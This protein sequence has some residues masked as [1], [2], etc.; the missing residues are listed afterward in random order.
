M[1]DITLSK[2]LGNIH[3]T[4]AAWEAECGQVTIGGEEL[5]SL[6]QALDFA[7]A[8]AE[9]ME[10]ELARAGGGTAPMGAGHVVPFPRRRHSCARHHQRARHH[11]P[12]QT[13]PGDRPGMYRAEDGEDDNG[14]DAA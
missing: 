9:S 6:V 12:R 13:R 4:F 14:G 7:R 3:D 2:T 10:Q 11:P 1:S 5:R 8:A